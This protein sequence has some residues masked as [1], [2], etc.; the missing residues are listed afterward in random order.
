VP[1]VELM[2]V[3]VVGGAAVRV[4]VLGFVRARLGGLRG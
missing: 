4:L 2:W 3:G 1:G